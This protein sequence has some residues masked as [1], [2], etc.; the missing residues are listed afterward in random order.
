MSQVERFAL[1]INSPE[2][3]TPLQ[4][5]RETVTELFSDEGIQGE[6]YCGEQDPEGVGIGTLI[7]TYAYPGGDLVTPFH[8]RSVSVGAAIVG[9]DAQIPPK[10]ISLL[11]IMTA[12]DDITGP[13]RND[14][15]TRIRSFS[16]NFR[17]NGQD[18]QVMLDVQS[19]YKVETTARDD[20]QTFESKKHEDK[21]FR[22]RDPQEL[23]QRL[24]WAAHLVSVF[25]KPEDYPNTQL[26]T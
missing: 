8:F 5:F 10:E 16:L 2:L 17:P 24:R 11:N 9:E 4:A 1:P 21:R 6:T 26:L 14:G 23:S 22:I 7:A 3:I 19:T 20:A 13:G 25:V 18:N 15:I 12:N